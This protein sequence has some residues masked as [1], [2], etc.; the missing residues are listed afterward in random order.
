MPDAV[1][2]AIAAALK[3][4][5]PADLDALTPPW[6]LRARYGRQVLD[7]M[8]EIQT[9]EAAAKEKR[10]LA[11][12]EKKQAEAAAEVAAKAAQ[13]A[14]LRLAREAHFANNEIRRSMPKPALPPVDGALGTRARKAAAS[15]SSLPQLPSLSGGLPAPVLQQGLVLPPFPR[16]PRMPEPP[17]TPTTRGNT[18]KRKAETPP[19]FEPGPS[20]LSDVTNSPTKRTSPSKRPAAK[21]AK[22]ESTSAGVP[23]SVVPTPAPVATSSSSALLPPIQLELPSRRVTRSSTRRNL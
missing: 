15:S 2:D 20:S 11:A 1:L 10:R 16:L 12:A 5:H 4:F 14:Q 6:S 3:L 8:H 18:G 23:A 19:P 21:R 9:E 7:L 13:H 17:R 22:R